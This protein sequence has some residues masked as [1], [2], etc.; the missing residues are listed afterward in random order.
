MIHYPD[1]CVKCL[2]YCRLQNSRKKYIRIESKD[3]MK[4]LQ[5]I[6]L[7]KQARQLQPRR[8]VNFL[9]LESQ[10]LD[11]YSLDEPVF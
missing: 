3:R 5:E 11:R 6:S 7:S 1:Y 8:V 9:R 10:A 2:A 4:L